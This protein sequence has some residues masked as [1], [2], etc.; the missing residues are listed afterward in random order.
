M[1]LPKSLEPVNCI[2]ALFPRGEGSV[3]LLR[4]LHCHGLGK[5]I[6]CTRVLAGDDHLLNDALKFR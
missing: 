1:R 3:L 4:L 2:L 6:R 5:H